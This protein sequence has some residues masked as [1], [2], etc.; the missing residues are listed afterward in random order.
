M[1]GLENPARPSVCVDLGP[2]SYGIHIGAGL[3]AH[4]AACLPFSMAGRGAYIVTDAHV[5]PIYDQT[6]T[7]ALKDAG[8]RCVE[9]LILPPGEATKNFAMLERVTGWLLEHGVDRKSVVF[10]LGGGVIGDLAGF[11]AAI[12]MRGLSYVQIP[13]TLLAQVD[14]SVGGKTAIDT[15]A[16]KNLVGAFHQPAAVV[17]DMDVLKTLPDREIRAGYAEV[18]KYG[19]LGD[20]DFFVTL[21]RDVKAFESRDETFL[22]RIVAHSCR[23]KAAIVAQ[24]ERESGARALLNLGHTFGH[25]LELASG[26]DG[27]L[28]H[29]EAVSIGMVL[30]FDLSVR[31]GICPPE[32]AARVRDHLSAAGLPTAICDISPALSSGPLD[33]IEIMRGDKKSSGGEIGFILVRGIGQAFFKSAPPMDLVEA[34]L[35]ES[36]GR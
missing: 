18:V 2:R 23:A 28:I 21:E 30:A 26:L 13:T 32:D 7:R 15:P 6:L 10:A 11:A 9:T 3:L 17:I 14:S 33:L 34:V 8:A 20:A 16:G 24:D 35:R 27:A 1:S 22:A 25:A 29:G 12:T 36:A 19:L 4:V 5:G 31:M